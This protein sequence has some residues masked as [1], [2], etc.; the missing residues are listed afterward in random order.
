MFEKEWDFVI[1][2][3]CRFPNE[4][5]IMKANFDSIHLRVK[6]YNFES[7][8]SEEQQNHISETALDNTAPDFWI[9]NKGS[10]TDLRNNI[11][12]LLKDIKAKE[13][14]N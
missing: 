12:Y 6:R 1:I 2:P 8:L 7:P 11:I 9:E 3:D 13:V 14:N 4:I 5:N 10:K